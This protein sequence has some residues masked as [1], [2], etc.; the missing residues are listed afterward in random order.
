[1]SNQLRHYR[2]SQEFETRLRQRYGRSLKNP[3][4][5]FPIQNDI[6]D[7][8]LA[9]KSR[10]SRVNQLLDG[11]SGLGRDRSRG[12][13]FL[14]PLAGIIGW[15]DESHASPNS[16][17]A[18]GGKPW[19][20]ITDWTA[21]AFEIADNVANIDW[22]NPG[23]GLAAGGTLLMTQLIAIRQRRRILQCMSAPV[24][25]EQ[26]SLFPE[27]EK[28]EEN[29]HKANWAVD[30]ASRQG[31]IRKENQDAFTV[32]E[33]DDAS[34]V[35][36]VCDGAGGIK[37]GRAAA[38]SAVV[39]IQQSLK[40]IQ[41]ESGTLTL[42]DLETAIAEARE[43]GTAQNLTGVTTALV[44][45][46]QEEQMTYATLG[47]GAIVVI[48]PDGMVNQVQVPHHSAGAPSNVINAYI[49]GDCTVPPRTGT[50]R[51]EEGSIVLA[52]SDGAS[53]LFPYEDFALH[54]EDYCDVTG[55][56]DSILAQIEAARDPDSNAY[57]HHDNMT[58]AMARLKVGGDHA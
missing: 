20:E 1:M 30:A 9:N 47:D 49:G 33:F 16:M 42:D 46:L 12:F 57:L 6:P 31:L 54:R 7:R 4:Q 40:E 38:Q 58:L 22:A 55:L 24:E 37:G 39:A 53:D 17:G 11:R 19:F 10:D 44:V 15:P 51:L 56:A 26:L 35:L 18:S 5:R 29:V 28:T 36:I 48:W 27:I 21:R 43:A 45:L 41:K 34:K 13:G 3:N 25:P 23:F 14:A 32:L 52:M 2:S 8:I 50:S